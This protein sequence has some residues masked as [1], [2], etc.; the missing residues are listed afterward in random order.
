[1]FIDLIVM[2]FPSFIKRIEI[3]RGPGSALYGQ[4]AFLAVINIISKKAKD[5]DG[6]ILESGGGSFD[7]KN[8]NVLM[9][10]VLDDFKLSTY[11]DYLESGGAR[12]FIEEDS[13]GKRGLETIKQE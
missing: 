4:N 11:A 10:K 8:H 9:G 7:T 3:I 1:M 13:T 2:G 6:I 5:I 12:L